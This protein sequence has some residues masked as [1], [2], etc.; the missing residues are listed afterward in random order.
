VDMT[1][2]A[3]PSD[4]AESWTVFASEKDREI[5]LSLARGRYQENLLRGNAESWSG[6]TLRGKARDWGLQYRR[7]RESLLDRMRASG[8]KLEFRRV[9]RGRRMV[10]VVG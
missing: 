10:L 2:P 8:L 9:G 6:S 1:N 5:A 7:S 4:L 3:N